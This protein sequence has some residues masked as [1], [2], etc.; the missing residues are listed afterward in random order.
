MCRIHEVYK[1]YNEAIKLNGIEMIIDFYFELLLVS[2]VCWLIYSFEKFS[3]VIVV[4]VF[5]N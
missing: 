2:L 3:C 1:H 5:N 4:N